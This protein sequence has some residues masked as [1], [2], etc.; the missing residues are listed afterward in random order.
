M[1]NK[2]QSVNQRVGKLI[3]KYVCEKYDLL[4][5]KRQRTKGYFDGCSKDHIYEIKAVKTTFRDTN[6]RITIINDNH[7]KLEASKCGKYLIINYNLIDKDKNLQSIQDINIR[8]EIEISSKIMSEIISK[9]GMP[10]TRK[11]KNGIRQHTRIKFNDI[12]K[13]VRE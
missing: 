8:R 12:S 6:P 2:N 5:N 13:T 11:Y 3:E 4:P 10:H 1:I 9:D 7:K